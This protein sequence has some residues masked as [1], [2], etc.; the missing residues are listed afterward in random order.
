MSIRSPGLDI[1]GRRTDP[2][3]FVS[4]FAAFG[5]GIAGL[6]AFAVIAVFDAQLSASIRKDNH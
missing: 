5:E 6:D 4:Q 3:A 2:C 1:V